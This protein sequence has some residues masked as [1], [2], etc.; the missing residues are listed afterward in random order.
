VNRRSFVVGGIGSTALIACRPWTREAR[1][2]PAIEELT[3]HELATIAAIADTFLPA[4]PSGAGPSA[5]DAGALAV[6]V[7]PAYGLRPYLPRVVGDVDDWTGLRHGLHRFV[8]LSPPRRELVLEQRMGLRGGL[9]R[10]WYLPAYEAIL[11]LTKLAVYGVSPF[12]TSSIGF[13]GPSAGYAPDS[14]AGVH[15]SRDLPRSLARGASSTIDVAGAGKVTCARIHLLA[16]DHAGATSRDTATRDAVGGT[17]R[18]AVM[19][20]SVGA[21]VRAMLRI[22]APGGRS[23]ELALRVPRLDVDVPLTG[24]PAAGRWRLDVVADAGPPVQLALWSLVVRTDLDGL[25]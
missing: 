7:D 1:E 16:R 17:T 19:R 9:I 6:I 18:D 3:Q 5:R 14:A 25:P 21:T 11:A 4:G 8:E 24:G 20:D 23:Q 15:T 2:T 12:G 10:S 13:P 22:T